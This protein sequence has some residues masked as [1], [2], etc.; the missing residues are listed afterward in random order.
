MRGKIISSLLIVAL[1]IL[2]GALKYQ[3]SA[4][5]VDVAL[6]QKFHSHSHSSHQSLKSTISSPTV[7]KGDTLPTL[8][9]SID[10]SV[11]AD[12]KFQEWIESEAKS[13]DSVKVSAKEKQAQIDALVSELTPSQSR[14]LK[15][16][17]MH[18]QSKSREK[19][20]SVYLLV[21]GGAKTRDDL[22]DV[23]IAPLKQKGGEVHSE[24][25]HA[26]V[27]E[28]SL[29]IMAIDGLFAQAQSNP[30]AR[31]TLARAIEDS[32]DPYIKAYA[33]DKYDQLSQR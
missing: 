8:G 14:Q 31:S 10:V 5:P 3:R 18:P 2:F 9:N 7:D 25:E 17:V 4:K 33:Q 13:L 21:E 30:Q 15:Q 32:A 29:R 1:V 6:A 23:I 19:I 12:P 22:K 20:L 11:P 26:G 24:E 27:R 28:K 16:T